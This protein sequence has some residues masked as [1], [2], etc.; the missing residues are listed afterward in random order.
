[1]LR[2]VF[3][4]IVFC[5]YSDHLASYCD[6]LNFIIATQIHPFKIKKPRITQHLSR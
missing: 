1:M 2:T 4:T 6:F 3:L 5:C